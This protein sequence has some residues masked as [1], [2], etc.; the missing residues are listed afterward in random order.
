MCPTLYP[1][2]AS[3][4]WKGWR[5]RQGK[6]AFKWSLIFELVVMLLAV[7]C[8]GRVAFGLR[9]PYTTRM[10]VYREKKGLVGRGS[11]LIPNRLLILGSGVSLVLRLCP[12]AGSPLLRMAL[13]KA[14]M[15]LGDSGSG[16]VALQLR[17]GQ[18]TLPPKLTRMGL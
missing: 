7:V 10:K 3:P 13:E 17:M 11:A 1:L 18:R 9:A 2:P 5:L 16:R 4:D 8:R 12:G 6:L 14:V 15:G